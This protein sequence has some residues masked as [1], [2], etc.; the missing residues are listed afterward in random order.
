MTPEPRIGDS[1]PLIDHPDL[2]GGEDDINLPSGT[3]TSPTTNL[4]DH[5]SDMRRMEAQERRERM[6]PSEKQVGR[7]PNE[8]AGKDQAAFE[9]I[10]AGIPQ[11]EQEA[12]RMRIKEKT[13]EKRRQSTAKKADD[14]KAR[15][16]EGALSDI[17]RGARSKKSLGI[18]R[19]PAT[20]GD[21]QVGLS[22]IHI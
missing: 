3:N 11:E 5:Y 1:S 12:A 19:I 7:S 6:S 10:K 18:T 20:N 9:A 22:L 2:P 14:F 15:F 13:S 21:A 8:L 4:E 16:V 17:V